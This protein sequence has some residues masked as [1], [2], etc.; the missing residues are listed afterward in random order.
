MPG[1]PRGLAEHRLR[2]DSSAKPVKE[3]L[4][5]SAVQKRK[6]IGEEVARL[7]AAGFIREIYHSEW[8]ANVVMV[9]KKDKSLRMCI[10]FKHINRACPKDHFPLPRIDQIVDST[11]G[12]ERL[13]FLDAYSGYHQIRLYGPD[14]V[15]TAFITP[16]GCF[17]YITMPF[18]LKNAGATFMR[19]IQKC[20]LTQISR[21]VEAYMDDIVVKSRK[22]SDLLADLAE[23]FANLRRYDIKLNP[24]KCTFGVPGGKL[25]GFLV[26]ERGIDANPEKIGTILRMKRPVRVHDVQKLTGCL[27]A[28]SRFISRL[29]EKAL[30]L[31]RLMKK[32]DKFE[33]TP[34]ADAAFAE[35]K[36]LLSTQ[37]VLAAPI[38]KEP[39]LLYIAAT[40]QVVSTV[41]TVERE[42]E[43]KALK[44]QRPVYYLSEVLTPS[45]QRYPHYQ[46]LVYGIYM[47]T[48]KVAHYFSDHSITVVSD[49]PLSEILHNRDATGRVAKW[50]IELLPLD[51]KFE[52]KKAIKS[53][54]I[55]DFLAEWIE[56]QQPTEVHSEHWTMFFDGSK[57]LNGSGAGVVLVSPRGDKLRYVLQIHFDSSNNEAEYEALLYGLRMAISLGVRRLMVYGDSDLVVNQVMKE[58]DVRSPAMTGYCSAVRKLEKKFEGLE[59]HHIPRLKN[60]AAD[61]LAKIG[62]KREAIPSGVFLEHIHTPSVKEDP[63]TEETPQPKSATD[64]TEVEVPAVVDL[65]MEVLVV[66][67]D[68]TIPYVAYILRKE[69]PEDEEEAR[70]IVRR[71]KAF[72]V[73]KGQLY[74]ES[75]TGVGQKCITPEEGRLILNDIH[76]GTC[77]HH[78]SSRTI[79]AKAYRAGFYWPKANEMAKE[80]VDKCE[81]CQFYSNMSH[82]PASALKTIP[83]VW[84][85]AVW[86]LDMIGPLRT[87]RSGFT[88]V[89]VAVDKFTKWI[90]AKPIKSLDTGTAVSF[91]RELI[92]RYG[93]PHSII[94]DN[95]SNFDSEEFRTFCNSQGTRVDYAS[96][97][98]PQSNGQAERAN[99]LILKGLKPRLM[100][101]LKHAAGAWVDELPSVLWGLRT[102]PNRSTGRTPFFLVYGAEAVLPSDLLHNA[103][104]VEIYNEAEAEQ[105]RQDAVDLLEEEREMALIRSTIY[106]QDLRRFH[107]RNVRGRAFQEGDLV[108]RVDQHKPHKL[109]PSWEGPFI[110]TKV[111]HNGAYRLY[112]VEHNIDEPRAWNAELLRPFYT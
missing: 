102:T 94:T 31:Y 43:G 54:A 17:C 104:R 9:P 8:L 75:A 107:A 106:Q 30:P 37:P 69:L 25:L 38:S 66:I 42:E 82:K 44:V 24:S 108:L 11:A 105:A 70:Q 23:T 61:D 89:L 101:D 71:S 73:I 64:P 41:L 112:N 21:N 59:L 20:L 88:H 56:Q 7:L 60:Q 15:K 77:G 92:F 72:T 91:I 110:V 22:G 109:A 87:G 26:S 79:V 98:H 96:V 100:R 84:P 46:K 12:C 85:F 40:G 76:S 52:A 81:G 97:A 18:G 2:V 16:F 32:A 29:G 27:A 63:F 4:R 1:V 13:S 50:A 80:I 45:K 10:D 67:P 51:I 90:E 83:L 111:L 53:Q 5:R 103:P 65:I 6:A 14:E 55:A 3:H 58:W 86:G 34:E 68:W 74:R 19:M 36:A 33:W 35:L 49:A 48:K 93:V 57:M 95:G 39:L 62:S 78:A 47:T 28:L 99:G